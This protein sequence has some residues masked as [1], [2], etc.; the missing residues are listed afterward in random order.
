MQF[1]PNFYSLAVSL[2]ISKRGRRS[3]KSANVPRRVATSPSRWL[4]N[5][6]SFSAVRA[7]PG[8]PTA[9]SS[10]TLRKGGKFRCN[11]YILR[12][13][14][15]PDPRIWLTFCLTNSSF[16]G[17]HAYQRNTYCVAHHRRPHDDMV[18]RW[19]VSIVTFTSSAARLTPLCPMISIATISIR[20][21]GTLSYRPRTVR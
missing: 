3:S 21:Y 15:R 12:H 1:Y 20:K 5:Q 4:E 16:S 10:F 18:T 14:S 8:Q 2:V 11:A 7:G 9:S 6:C 19:S 17:G 13:T